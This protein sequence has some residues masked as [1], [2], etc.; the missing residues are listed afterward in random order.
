MHF[1]K[2]VQNVLPSCLVLTVC[3]AAH[4]T[5]YCVSHKRPEIRV[6]FAFLA[7][8]LFRRALIEMDV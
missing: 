4:Y 8:H 1:E 6:T 2:H 3:P 5:K 7:D